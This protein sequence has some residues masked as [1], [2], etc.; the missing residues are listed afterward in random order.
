MTLGQRIQQLRKQKGLSQEALGEALGVSR[1]A[2]SKWEGDNGI[3]ELDTL[4]AMSRLFAVPLGELLGVEEP[5]EEAQTETAP[6]QPPKDSRADEA[7]TRRVLEEYVR[8]TRTGQTRQRKG[9][10]ILAGILAGALLLC[11]TQIGTLRSTVSSLRSQVSRLESRVDAVQSGI[12]GQIRD[13]IYAV[14]EE[15]ERL[16]SSFSWEIVAFDAEAETVTVDFH[17][18]MKEYPAG[19]TARFRV[20]WEGGRQES[21]WCDGP[22]FTSRMTLPMNGSTEVDLRVRDGEGNIREQTLDTLYGLHTDNFHL[23]ADSLAAVFAF[24]VNLSWGS[25]STA[26][27]EEPRVCI[28]SDW[29]ELLWPKTAEIALSVGD[30]QVYSGSMT[31]TEQADGDGRFYATLPEKYVQRLL[32]EGQA[33]KITLSVTDNLGRTDVFSR[34]GT[35]REGVLELDTIEEV[36]TYT[37]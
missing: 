10:A 7:H 34:G 20:S 30:E 24:S 36:V 5:R 15:N 33:V 4:I 13:S 29:P 11:L 27:S 25:T 17:A 21:D 16:I 3:P 37:R 6:P 12:S 31:I 8:R 35:V 32:A 23:Q 1:Q 9:A 28:T 19:G 18:T 22:D 2:V 14:L 26:L